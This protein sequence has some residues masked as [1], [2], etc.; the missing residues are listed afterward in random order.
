MNQ[1]TTQP[2]SVIDPVNKAFE[3]TRLILFSPFDIGKWFALGFCAWLAFL[4]EGGGG[5]G[6][7]G[8][9]GGRPQFP[10]KHEVRHF[11]E[12]NMHWILPMALT[13]AVIILVITLGL[14]FLRCRGKF[15]FLN[16]VARNTDLIIQP[17]KDYAAQANSLFL[18][19]LCVGLLYMVCMIPIVIGWLV[20]LVPIIHAHEAGQLLAAAIGMICLLASVTILL[21][22]AFGI[23]SKLTEHFVVPVM[24]I[25]RLRCLEA[26]KIFW[27]L[28]KDNLWQF[29]IFL[30]FYMVLFIG[31]MAIFAAL[32]FATC[33]CFCC[34]TAIPYIG[35]VLLLPF[36]VFLRS[37]SALYLAQYG[38]QWDVF[39]ASAVAPQVVPTPAPYLEP[40]LSSEPTE[41]TEPTLPSDSTPP[42]PPKTPDPGFYD[43]N[44]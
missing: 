17:W 9:G 31:F 43:P 34:F 23:I 26:W 33:C 6:G 35:T 27:G 2:I 3:K 14:L 18:F 39:A 15:M 19:K 29:F 13:I 28:L 22:M 32:G 36:Y 38:P 40:T 24:Y 21:G 42:T 30:L 1:T 37:Y 12:A 4:G 11:F 20:V 44:L 25:H 5:S 7:G 10:S 41:P 16:G 8:D